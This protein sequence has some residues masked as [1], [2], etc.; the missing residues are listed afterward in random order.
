MAG[1]QEEEMNRFIKWLSIILLSFM[2]LM[3]LSLIL[4]AL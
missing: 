3:L 2:A 1:Q 4:G